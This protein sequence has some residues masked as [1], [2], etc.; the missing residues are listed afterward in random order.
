M[1]IFPFQLYDDSENIKLNDM[2]EVIG[3]L[4]VDPALSGEFQP[5]KDPLIDP[6]AES[7]VETITHNPPPSLV[8]RLHAVYV[9]KLDHCNPLVRSF[10]QG[11]LWYKPLMNLYLICDYYICIIYI[12]LVIVIK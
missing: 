3:F 6:Q 11:M 10:D 2:I 9:K 7:D 12:C 8:P 4:S 1:F 5:E